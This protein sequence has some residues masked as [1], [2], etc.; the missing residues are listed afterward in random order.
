MLAKT[1]PA[2]RSHVNGERFVNGNDTSFSGLQDYVKIPI[3][4]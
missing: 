4:Y 3:I 1:R 2:Q